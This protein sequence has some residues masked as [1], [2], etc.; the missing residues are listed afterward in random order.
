MQRN[1]LIHFIFH[2]FKL[3]GEGGGNSVLEKLQSVVCLCHAGFGLRCFLIRYNFDNPADFG[4]LHLF[5]ASESELYYN[6]SAFDFIPKTTFK[7]WL[8]NSQWPGMLETS[9]EWD[10]REHLTHTFKLLTPDLFFWI[11]LKSVFSVTR[12]SHIGIIS[13]YHHHCSV[14]NK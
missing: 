4:H 14:V 11:D 10:E 12:S 9:F 8:Q 2:L 3:W 1:F 7:R 6:R 5:T 13:N